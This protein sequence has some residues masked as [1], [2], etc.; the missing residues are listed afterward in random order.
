MEK[1]K[2]KKEGNFLVMLCLSLVF[3]QSCSSYGDWELPVY[4]GE[5][6]WEQI[7]NKAAWDK[8]LDYE[9]TVLNN[10]LYLVGGYNPGNC[11]EDPYFEDV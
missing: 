3:F 2:Y 7:T 8:R 11:S 1:L 6:N 4:D 9:V 10:E 5:L